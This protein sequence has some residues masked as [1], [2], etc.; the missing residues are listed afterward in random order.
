MNQSEVAQAFKPDYARRHGCAWFVWGAPGTVHQPEHTGGWASIGGEPA[1][2]FHRP[3]DLPKDVVW[4]TNLTKAESWSLGRW[5]HIKHAGFLGPD[6]LTLMSEWGFPQGIEELKVA[7]SAWAEVLGRLAEWL[8]RWATRLPATTTGPHP[9]WSWGDG[10]WHEVLAD[11]LG[12][13]SP[14]DDTHPALALAFLDQVDQEIPAMR[15]D[16][17]RKISVPLPRAEHA[18]RLWA[19][20]YPRGSWREVPAQEWAGPPDQVWEWIANQRQPLLVRFDEVMWRPG[21]ERE[22]MLWWGLRGRRFAAAAMDPVW[23]TAEDALEMNAY[24]SAVPSAMLRSDSWTRTDDVPNWSMSDQGPLMDN[25]IV[26]GLLGEALW[27]AAATPVRTSTKR[28]KSG[29]SSRAVWWR[30][31]DRRAC[32]AAALAFMKRGFTVLSYGQGVVTVLFNPATT[33]MTDWH[34]ALAASGVRVPTMLAAGM[35]H[36]STL[37]AASL[38]VWLKSASTIEPWLLMDRLLWPWMGPDKTTLKPI[39]EHAMRTL[40]ARP[41]PSEDW[42]KEW[43]AHLRTGAKAAVQSIV[44][45][46]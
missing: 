36:A 29:V 19:T 28:I 7:C 37:N 2:E 21:L 39:L 42:A 30:A 22:A 17:Q 23:M 15:L 27:R 12:W 10:E 11:R 13:V 18:R 9:A 25:S 3:Q 34:A 33:L 46:T 5:S 14:K 38:D 24:V 16:G 43:K 41:A 35:P 31:S 45:G 32:F 44:D 8:S 40:A 20:R 26:S 4:W 1:F 6:W